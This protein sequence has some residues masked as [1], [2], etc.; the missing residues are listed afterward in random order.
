MFVILQVHT[1][2]I[3]INPFSLD[4]FGSDPCS[5]C[6]YSWLNAF[7]SNVHGSVCRAIIIVWGHTKGGDTNKRTNIM[8]MRIFK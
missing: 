8:A 4:G 7:V 5:L 6:P 1:D 2:N 3:A